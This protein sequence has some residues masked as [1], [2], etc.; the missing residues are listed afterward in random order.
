M[1][2][3]ENKLFPCPHCNRPTIHAANRHRIHWVKHLTLTLCTCGC[4]GAVLAL[5]ILWRML[6]GAGGSKWVCAVCGSVK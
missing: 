4:W 2:V 3:V 1:L 6:F 5:I